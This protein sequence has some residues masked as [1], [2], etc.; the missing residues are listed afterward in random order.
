MMKCP[1]IL[2]GDRSIWSA[3]P[4]YGAGSGSVAS[5]LGAIR[6]ATSRVAFEGRRGRRSVS[7]NESAASSPSVGNAPSERCSGIEGRGISTEWIGAIACWP[8]AESILSASSPDGAKG[9]LVACRPDGA[10]GGFVPCRPDEPTGGFVACGPDGSTGGFVPCGPD[11]SIGGLALSGPDVTAV[12]DEITTAARCAE[13][14]PVPRRVI[15]PGACGAECEGAM[16]AVGDRPRGPGASPLTVRMLGRDD[17]TG[18]TRS[19]APDAVCGRTVE[20]SSEDTGASSAADDAP[21]GGCQ[22][23]VDAP[24]GGGTVGVGAPGGG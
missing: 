6:A 2:P 12:A 11:R 4:P 10:T 21:V 1:I 23:A 18:S 20:G 15:T 14:A 22:V 16:P 7:A 17:R 19:A 9:G 13:T 5:S 8:D 3:K 24:G